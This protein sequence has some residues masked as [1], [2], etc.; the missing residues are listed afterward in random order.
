[1]SRNPQAASSPARKRA[2]LV[3]P[4][5]MSRLTTAAPVS[6][7]KRWAPLPR[8]AMAD[9]RSGPAV[10]TTK[11]PARP[12]NR[13]RTR[14]AFLLRAASPVMMTAPVASWSGRRPQA[15]YSSATSVRRASPSMVQGFSMGVRW[16]GLR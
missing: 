2:A 3:V 6:S 7:E 1:M 16:M 13:S 14:A 5:P 9:S 11:S 12:L 8:P 10:S 4:P 15:A